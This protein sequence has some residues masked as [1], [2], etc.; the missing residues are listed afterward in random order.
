MERWREGER[1][2]L[3]DVYWGVGDC[4]CWSLTHCC[5]CCRCLSTG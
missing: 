5:W 1:W 3:E 2:S 4:E